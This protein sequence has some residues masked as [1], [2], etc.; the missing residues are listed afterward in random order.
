MMPTL[1]NMNPNTLGS[2]EADH[3]YRSHIDTAH[4]GQ[5]N[6]FNR[7]TKIAVNSRSPDNAFLD[8]SSAS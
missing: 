6:D 1:S 7:K 4:G 8:K 5:G 3:I 2:G